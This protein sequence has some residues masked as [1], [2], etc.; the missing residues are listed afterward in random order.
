M[1]CLFAGNLAIL[2]IG[3]LKAGAHRESIGKLEAEECLLSEVTTQS[4][5]G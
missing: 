4:S 1:N 3:L 2:L 5:R